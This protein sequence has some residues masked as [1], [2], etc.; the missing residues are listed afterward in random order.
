MWARL[1]DPVLDEISDTNLEVPIWPEATEERPIEPSRIFCAGHCFLPDGRLLVAG[2]ERDFPYPYQYIPPLDQPVRGLDYTFIF[3]LE[4]NP[5]WTVPLDQNGEP[6]KMRDGRWYPSLTILND[7]RPLVMGGIGGSLNQWYEVPVNRFSEIYTNNDGW[8]YFSNPSADMPGGMSYF[9]PAGNVIPFGDFAGKVFFS[10]TAA[11]PVINPDPPPEFNYSGIG[12]AQ[13]FDPDAQGNDPFWQSVGN[14]REPRE[15]SNHVLLPIRLGKT[16]AKVA[17]FGGN[18]GGISNN[19]DII[20][21]SEPTPD[22]SSIDPMTT[23]RWRHNSIILPDRKI[24]VV[25]GENESGAVK[26]A[27]LLD[28]DT[29]TWEE[30]TARPPEMSIPRRYH[31][32]ALLLPNAKVFLGGGRVP[33]GGDVEDDTERRI[34]IFTPGYLLD[35]TRPVIT[36][37]PTE[38]TYEEVFTVALGGDYTLDSMAFIR[39]MSVTHGYNS[40]QRYIELAFEPDLMVGRY[41]VTAPANSHIAPPGYYMLFVIRDPSESTSGLSKIPSKAVL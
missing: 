27:E 12:L 9:Y 32:T 3:D 11:I 39:P 6:M 18:W 19:V 7:G 40:E 30:F 4:N 2:G 24:L 15:D 34:E 23:A 1:Y 37:A 13:I 16:S 14:T 25:G 36:D 22:W 8:I 33:D 10:S 17:V 35:G 5:A 31:S 20:D 38:V 29:L 41:F 28:T 26:T 21:L